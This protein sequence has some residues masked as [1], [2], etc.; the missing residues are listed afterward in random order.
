M[1]TFNP[2]AREALLLAA[3]LLLVPSAVACT[4]RSRPGSQASEKGA[5]NR[6][7][8]PVIEVAP[9]DAAAASDDPCSV[10]FSTLF[11]AADSISYNGYEVVR[12][13]KTIHDKV[14]SP[15]IPVSY[16]ILKS[17]GRTIAT[18]E[19]VYFGLGNDTKFGFASLLGAETRQLLVS[20]TIP[21]NGRHWIV[22]LSSKAT[23]VFDSKEWDLGQEDVCIHDFDDDGV[24]E[25]SLAVTSFWGFGAMSMAESP[26]PCVVFKYDATARKYM[27]DKAAFAGALSDIDEDVQ[28]IDPD[29]NP[30]GG[31]NGPYLATRLD[32]FLRYAYAGRE[33]DAWSFFDEQYNLSDKE[34]V[35]R[36][37]KR[38]LETE[39]VYRYVYGL[40]PL[41]RHSL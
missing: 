15:D 9:V 36:G 40:Q 4:V 28:R 25:I 19:G 37:I 33:N 39:P 7:A 35:K 38:I 22:D 27:P 2:Q 31:S 30:R 16:A 21:H 11:V 20:Q 13:H 12:L 8:D 5:A 14:T 6:S 18:F 23:T 10:M 29:E 34:D 24:Q 32:V 1:S 3:A 41:K 17:G 26:M